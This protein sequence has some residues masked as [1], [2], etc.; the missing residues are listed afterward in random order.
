MLPL[1][2]VHSSGPNLLGRNWIKAVRYSVPQL[3]ALAVSE[4][5]A[6][7]DA[8]L[9]QLKEEFSSLFAPGLGKF[10]GPPVNIPIQDNAQPV[11]KKARAVPLA[12]R[13][14]AEQEL[15]KLVDQDI[16][17]PVRFSRW[18]TPIVAVSKANGDLRLCGDYKVTVNRV[19]KAESYPIPRFEDL[20]AAL[21]KAS[22]FSKLDLSQAYQQLVVDEATQ[23]LLTINTHRG[24]FKVK[25]LAFGIS[26]APG[27]FQRVMETILQGL[28]GVVVFLDDIL[29]VGSTKTEHD[30]R[31]R[32]VLSRLQSAGLRLRADKC[33]ICKTQ[34]VFLG[35]LLS[36]NG[37]QPLADKVEAIQ[38]VPT[39]ES[40]AD[41]KVFLGML[42]YYGRFLPGLAT[43]VEPL[44]RLLDKGRQWAWT[45]QCDQAFRMA[46]ALLS[47]ES[48]LVHLDPELPTILSV[49]ASPYGLGAVLAHQMPDGSERPIAFASRTRSVAERRY[50]Q[51][52]REALAVVFGI[53]KFH[54]YHLDVILRS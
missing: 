7:A 34:V 42:Q 52:D 16:L 51:V 20:L 33:A 19:A 3:Q 44:H 32:M 24:L 12:V 25:R 22:Y 29:I 38:H 17:E 31:L 23:E 6:Y 53:K 50:A 1:L 54:M 48:V 36:A 49:D 8:D 46:K 26:S 40:T 5:S 4:S 37:I 11:F 45:P 35:H 30:A 28:P 18:A 43:V 47:A 15:N 2:V 21:P 39:P 13:E 9:S 14:R 10:T 41:V 27:L